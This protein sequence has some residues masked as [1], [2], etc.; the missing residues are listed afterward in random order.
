LFITAFMH[1][2]DQ[3]RQEVA[4]A[5]LTVSDLVGVEGLAVW[6]GHLAARWEDN[7]DRERILWAA[8]MVEKEQ[9]LIGLSPHL[10]VLARK[11]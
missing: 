6:L 11:P 5:G 8:R 10:L 9:T 7:A 3:L 1:H 2:P 4:E